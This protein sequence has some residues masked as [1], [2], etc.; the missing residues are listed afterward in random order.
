MKATADRVPLGMDLLG[1][2]SSPATTSLPSALCPYSHVN[3]ISTLPPQSRQCHQHSVPTVKSHHCHSALC[4]HSHI[5]SPP[6]CTLS[7]QSH[8]ITATL[9]SVPTV[10]S[11]HHH[12]VL[13]LHSHPT[14]SEPS[15]ISAILYSVHS[16]PTPSEL[17]R[18]KL[19]T[20][21]AQDFSTTGHPTSS[22]RK[23]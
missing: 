19:T 22:A 5:T 3:A 10:T 17:F 6:L 18:T 23:Q 7:P 15:H 21:Q 16:H 12:S 14:Q 1:S 13:C 20:S 9:H 2:F 4:P 11:H 8:H